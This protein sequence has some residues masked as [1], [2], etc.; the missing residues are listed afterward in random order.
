MSILPFFLLRDDAVAGF[1]CA[2]H[3]A[4]LRGASVA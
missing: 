4:A 1:F 2:M 3:D